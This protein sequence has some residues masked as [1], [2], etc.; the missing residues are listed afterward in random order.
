MA[1]PKGNPETLKVP[2]SAE[3][4][5]NGQK[6]GKA[7]GQARKEKATLKKAVEWLLNSDIKMTKGTM[8]EALKNQGIDITNLS[9]SQQAT[10]GLWYGAVTGNANN[11]KTL[12]EVNGETVEETH[13]YNPSIEEVEEIVDNS[14]LEKVLYEANKSD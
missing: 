7:S 9:S 11:F 10:I 5:I 3:A 13:T 2:T 6:G 14:N 12:M 4:R 8:V 1:N